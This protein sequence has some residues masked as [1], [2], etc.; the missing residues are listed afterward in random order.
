MK[1][2]LLPIL[3][4]VL[5]ASFTF[6]EKNKGELIHTGFTLA[7]QQYRALLKQSISLKKY[8]RTTAPD[9]SL[10]FTGIDDW[11]GGF[12]PGALWYVYE[13]AQTPEWKNA[14]IKWTE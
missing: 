12:W 5:V 11:T 7:E 13:Y 1:K 8:P 14:A 10:K 4:L 2:I 6:N 3:C 9:G